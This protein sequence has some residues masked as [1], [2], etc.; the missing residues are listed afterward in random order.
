[1]FTIDA[2]MMT[3]SGTAVSVP[4]ASPSVSIAMKSAQIAPIAAASHGPRL[5]MTRSHTSERP[6]TYSAAATMVGAHAIDA[7]PAHANTTIE[8]AITPAAWS[9]PL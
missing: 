1:M 4:D 7:T 2:R 9:S 6:T 5:R 3:A 8:A